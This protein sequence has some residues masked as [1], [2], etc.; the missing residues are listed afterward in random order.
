MEA[1]AENAENLFNDLGLSYEEAFSNDPQLRQFIAFAASKLPKRSRVLD[2]GCGTGKPV[3]EEL[4]S[5]DLIVHGIDASDE[6]VRLASSQVT[7]FFE[8]ADMRQYSPKVQFDG[9]FAIL[10]LFQ[11]TPGDICCMVT[12][13]SEWLRVGG[14]VA[15]GV[16]PSTALPPQKCTYDPTWDCVWM[17]GKFWMGNYTNESFFSEENW[18]RLLRNAGFVI[19]AEPV[20]YLFSPTGCNHPEAHYLIL[21]RKVDEQ[22]LL[23]PF[24]LPTTRKALP[25]TARGDIFIDRFESSDLEGLLRT[26]ESS[27]NVLCLGQKH[28]NKRFTICDAKY[29]DGPLD[30]LPFTDGSFDVVFAPWKLDYA[31]ELERTL[32]EIVRVANKSQSQI[33]LI[34]GAPGNEVVKHLN[35]VARS[36]PIEHQGYLLRCAVQH[37]EMAGF[38][39]ISLR[40]IDARYYFPEQDLTGRCSVAAEVLAGIWHKAHP[41]YNV[42]KEALISNLQL[43]FQGRTHWVGHEMVALVASRVEA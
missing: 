7:G 23:G 3:A 39:D 31:I 15:L 37:L 18:C 12:K 6:M 20:D 9:I 42:I 22:P 2:V 27:R 14:Y 16:T 29:F 5:A 40:R 4:S 25:R 8:K 24:P 1:H 38:G 26:H 13:F 43:H 17:I 21:A 28:E 35:T 11:L 10:S 32:A 36:L 30:K 33:I 41:Q 19:E 34:Q